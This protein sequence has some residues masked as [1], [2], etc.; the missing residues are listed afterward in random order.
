MSLF[1]ELLK[2][3]KKSPMET[4]HSAII[5]YRNKIIAKGHNT[6]RCSRIFSRNIKSYFLRGQ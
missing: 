4:P 6:Y 1:D 3:A 5:V 2:E